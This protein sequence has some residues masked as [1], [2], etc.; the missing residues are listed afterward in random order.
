M[1]RIIKLTESDLARI[2]KRVIVENES[3]RYS[4]AILVLL[5]TFNEDCVCGFEV[6]Y[7]DETDIYII[8]TIVGNKDLD[9]K[10]PTNYQIRNYLIKLKK[11]VND[12]IYDFLPIRFLVEFK[13][14]P[15]CEN[16]LGE[17]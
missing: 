1:K 13:Q 3:K 17:N 6:D 15:R 8:K 2:V 12:L 4:N 14:T 10:F 9:N 11:K 7:N 16:F 5:K